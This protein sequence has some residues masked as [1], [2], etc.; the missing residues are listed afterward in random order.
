MLNDRLVFV[1]ASGPVSDVGGSKRNVWLTKSK[2]KICPRDPTYGLSIDSLSLVLG[3]WT[4]NKEKRK[5]RIQLKNLH[6]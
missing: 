3:R 4:F 1:V 2:E 6:G 5:K